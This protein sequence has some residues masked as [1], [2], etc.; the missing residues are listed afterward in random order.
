MPPCRRAGAALP[1]RWPASLRRSLLRRAAALWVLNNSAPTQLPLFWRIHLRRRLPGRVR[2]HQEC[3]G[4]RR[5][6]KKCP[7]GRFA[8]WESWRASRRRLSHASF[9]STTGPRR[10]A[11]CPAWRSAGPSPCAPCHAAPSVRQFF[12]R[13]G[14]ASTKG[15]LGEPVLIGRTRIG[16]AIKRGW[17]EPSNEVGRASTKG[18][19]GEP[20]NFHSGLHACFKAAPAWRGA[21]SAC[22][23]R[24]VPARHM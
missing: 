9:S 24:L 6:E 5:P 22:S 7:H 3:S 1:G 10:T 21:Y 14:R 11:R 17:G 20:F 16:R 18:P 8:C 13:P 19:L 23:A 4:M 2:K 12:G 15:P